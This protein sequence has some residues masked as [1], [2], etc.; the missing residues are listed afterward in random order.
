MTEKYFTCSF[1][2]IYLAILPAASLQI[3]K[4]IIVPISDLI[5]CVSSVYFGALQIR[6][7]LE[8]ISAY[9]FVL[10]GM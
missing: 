2:E 10:V 6:P 3:T 7:C 4:S 9:S 5:M 1:C 8:A